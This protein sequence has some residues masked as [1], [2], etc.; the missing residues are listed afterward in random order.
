M[1]ILSRTMAS[2]GELFGLGLVV[3]IVLPIFIGTVLKIFHLIFKKFNLKFEPVHVFL[4]NYF[5]TLALN[6]LSAEIATISTFF[7]ASQDVCWQYL[8]FLF[9][10]M[11]LS[12]SLLCMQADRFL[13][14]LWSV[15][16]KARVTTTRAVTACSLSYLVS[17]ILTCA[18]KILVKSYTDCVFPYNLLH[19]RPSNIVLEGIPRILAVVATVAVSI[20]AVIVDRQLAK[21]QPATVNLPSNSQ[22]GTSNVR[23]INSDP[24]VFCVTE[25]QNL[26]SGTVAMDPVTCTTSFPEMIKNTTIMNIIHFVLFSTFPITVFLGLANTNCDNDTGG[27]DAYIFIYRCIAPL[28]L[29]CIFI[30]LALLYKVIKVKTM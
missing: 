13:A 17:I 3:F 5:G 21:L 7:P 29:M 28:R 20:Y 30:S 11:T 4:L 19:T 10:S 22:T 24:H 27:C 1:V 25:A 12:F 2:R 18:M 23:R 15:H 14:I 6:L 26:E 9:S 8:F 16:Y